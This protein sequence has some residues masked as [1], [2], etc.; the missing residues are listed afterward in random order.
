MSHYEI[1]RKYKNDWTKF[2]LL[3]VLGIL[4]ECKN[5]RGGESH[6][7]F[8][9]S[10]NDRE[11]I[12]KYLTKKPPN[13]LV[14]MKMHSCNLAYHWIGFL[15]NFLLHMY[16]H[17]SSLICKNDV[18]CLFTIASGH[19]DQIIKQLANSR[20]LWP[21]RYSKSTTKQGVPSLL[22]K[23][24]SPKPEDQSPE[25]FFTQHKKFQMI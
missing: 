23:D 18:I 13:H 12:K 8:W 9:W 25:E 3:Y 16:Y 6:E 15:F 21:D 20:I 5:P 1:A 4:I 10:S 2:P 11:L 24:R 22:T 7:N 14:K 17:Q 19:S